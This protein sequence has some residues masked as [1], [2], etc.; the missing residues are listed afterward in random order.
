MPGQ[1][2]LQKAS[3]AVVGAGGLGCP[4]VQY[5]AAAG[6]GQLHSRF[7]K[8]LNQISVSP[9]HIGVIDHDVVELSNLQRQ[10]LH[11]EHRIGMNKAESVAV[12]VKE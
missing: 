10:I 12:A 8:T 9:G 5:L 3:V 7:L 2:K 1:V 6:V 4:V 11:T